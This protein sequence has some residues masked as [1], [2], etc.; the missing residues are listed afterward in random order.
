MR[1]STLESD[2]GLAAQPA[3]TD[4]LE[5]SAFGAVY[6]EHRVSVFRYLR[7]RTR[8]ADDALD[9]TALTFERAFRNAGRFRA[10]DGGVHA[11]L[12]RIARNTAIDAH[13]RRR[14]TD[15]LTDANNALRQ[16]AIEADRLDQERTEILDLVARLPGD[17]RDAL[18]LRYAGGLTAR[19]IGAVI[20]KREAAVQKHI[21]RGLVTLREAYR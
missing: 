4:R 5:A 11:W 12:F 13:R 17:Q 16:L 2:P 1:A 9:L 3:M 21:E 10:H 14:P 20:G 6:E 15:D 7:G 18:L 8:S 19:E